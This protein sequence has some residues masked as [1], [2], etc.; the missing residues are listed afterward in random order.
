M[1]FV[2]AALSRYGR[3]AGDALP[4]R[5]LV[6]G[7]CGHDEYTRDAGEAH[8]VKEQRDKSYCGED[9]TRVVPLYAAPEAAQKADDADQLHGAADWLVKDMAKP[10]TPELA[11]RLLIG[12][13]RAEPMSDTPNATQPHG[14]RGE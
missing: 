4:V 8:R 7:Q 12:Y 9:E 1:T 14:E 6:T 5:W 2:R 13:N 10:R 3:P 11:A